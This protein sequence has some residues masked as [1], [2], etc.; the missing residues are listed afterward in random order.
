MKMLRMSTIDIQES[1]YSSSF[2]LY[3]HPFAQSHALRAPPWPLPPAYCALVYLP[4]TPWRRCCLSR[5][6]LPHAG[7]IHQHYVLALVILLQLST[8]LLLGICLMYCAALL[9]SHQAVGDRSFAVSAPRLWNTLPDDI[10]CTSA[11]ALL[12]FRRKLKTH[13][14]RQSYPDII[15]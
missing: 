6:T 2:P 3:F 1:F 10:T 13:L 14:C 8:A 9:T 5:R 12:L 7:P 11:P 15:L 4:I